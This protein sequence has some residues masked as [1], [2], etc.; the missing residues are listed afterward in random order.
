LTIVS[1]S[2]DNSEPLLRYRTTLSLEN[3]LLY[4]TQLSSDGQYIAAIGFSLESVEQR[5][6]PT[7]TYVWRLIRNNTFNLV[8]LGSIP[9]GEDDFDANIAFSPDVEF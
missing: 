4:R 3:D 6:Y 5:Q 2:Q 7:Y 8:L 9:M 1:Q